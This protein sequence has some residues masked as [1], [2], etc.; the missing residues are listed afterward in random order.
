MNI[1]LHFLRI[2]P[3]VHFLVFSATILSIS[4]GSVLFHDGSGNAIKWLKEMLSVLKFVRGIYFIDTFVTFRCGLCIILGWMWK[5]QDN[6]IVK[7][8]SHSV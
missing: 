3:I 4:Y 8:W 6:L 2:N 7:E 1:T 5:L